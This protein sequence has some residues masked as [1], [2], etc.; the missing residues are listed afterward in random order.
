MG[1]ALDRMATAFCKGDAMKKNLARMLCSLGKESFGRQVDLQ[2]RTKCVAVG[3]VNKAQADEADKHI[4]GVQ[5]LAEPAGFFACLEDAGQMRENRVLRYRSYKLLEMT[6]FI[7]IFPKQQPHKSGVRLQKR[8]VG[9]DR[10]LHGLKR[11]LCCIVGGEESGFNVLQLVIDHSEN[12]SIER[13]LA[14]EIMVDHPLVSLR[15]DYDFINRNAVV[16]MLRE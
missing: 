4:A 11:I 16:A 15:A 8:K 14:T 12:F 7:E 1:M 2:C 13:L 6:P 5:S 10:L 9:R 3:E